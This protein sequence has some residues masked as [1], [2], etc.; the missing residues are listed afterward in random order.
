MLRQVAVMGIVT[1][2]GAEVWAQ[3]FLMIHQ[4]PGPPAGFVA[5]VLTVGGIQGDLIFY[6]LALEPMDGHMI[7][8]VNGAL[9]DKDDG[10]Q[11]PD[12]IA[13]YP[14][15]DFD[16]YVQFGSRDATV[17][18]T[19]H[20]LGHSRSGQPTVL[21]STDFLIS[22]STD[23]DHTGPI[24]IGQIVLSDSSN[25]MLFYSISAFYRGQTTVGRLRI[26][27]GRGVFVPVP[28]AIWLG[29]LLL[30]GLGLLRVVRR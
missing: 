11:P 13:Q 15:Y 29:G 22:A 27:G 2:F 21:N 6:S 26:E 7:H 3:P 5:N 4:R 23:R 19:F 20:A 1:V 8:D 25:G 18:P 28:S 10:R 17:A 16:S 30:G 14:E 24:D 12:V 9:G